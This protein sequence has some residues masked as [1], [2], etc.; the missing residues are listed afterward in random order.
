MEQVQLSDLSIE[1]LGSSMDKFM[2][3]YPI[4][5]TISPNPRTMHKTT[6][7]MTDVNGRLRRVAVKLR[8]DQMKQ[9]DQAIYCLDIIQK[10][11]LPF[12]INPKLFGVIELN[13]KGNAHAHFVLSADNLRNATDLAI[14]R[15]DVSLCE[16]VLRN[17]ARTGKGNDYMNNIVS[18]NDSIT[19]RVKYMAKVNDE[20]KNHFK[21]YF[22]NIT[23]N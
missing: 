4:W 9:G 10:A 14:F 8:Y 3:R 12:L 6:V 17:V 18:I 15:R 13:Q 1:A 21:N 5:C 19:D 2:G 16:C 11:Y 7:Q 22:I 23:D 20:M